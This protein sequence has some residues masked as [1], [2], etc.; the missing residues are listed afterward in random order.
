M[1]MGDRSPRSFEEL[2]TENSDLKER[3]RLLE[4]RY[5]RLFDNIQEA[6]VLRKA[7]FDENGQVADLELIEANPSHL[8]TLKVDSLTEVQGRRYSELYTPGMLAWTIDHVRRAIEIGRPIIEEAH[9]DINN[10]YYLTTTT[11]VDNCLLLSTSVDITERK[12]VEEALRESNEYLER[13]IGYANAPIIVWSPDSVITRF[14]HAFEQ[15]TGIPASEAI[16]SDLSIL[17]PSSSKAS[18]MELIHHAMDGKQWNVVEIP[19][20]HRSGEVRTV[21]WNSANVM[22]SQ[23]RLRATIAQGQDITERVKAETALKKNEKRLSDAQHFAHLGSWEWDLRN[24]D[25]RWSAELYSIFGLSPETFQPTMEK[26]YE[27]IHPDDRETVKSD[28]QQL[29][30]QGTPMNIDF[31][32]IWGDSTVRIINCTGEVSGRDNEGEPQVIV[33][34]N[35]D[36]TERKRVEDEIRRS[37]AELQQFAYVASHDLQEPLRMVVSYLNLLER[38]CEAQ[39]DPKGQ[40]YIHYAVDGGKRMREL[41]DDLLEY[42]RI[43]TRS[44]D[45]SFVDMNQVVDETL[46]VLKVPVEESNAVI[47]VHPLPSLM[48]DGSQMVQLMQNLIGNAI[49]FRGSEPLHVEVNSWH[50]ASEYVISIKDNG[51]GIDEKYRGKLFQMFQRLHT[52]DEY[53]GTGIGLAISKKIVERHGGRIW[54]ES[55]GSHGSTF[56]FTISKDLRGATDE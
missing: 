14:N 1:M 47:V 10:R 8:K 39:L 41:I 32:I 20:Q 43:S 31:R 28:M 3:N 38:R 2:S 46:K 30:S 35:Q 37:N 48:A 12:M 49:K 15:L 27:C 17:F 51:I 33:G 56:F 19:I 26:F 29:V 45:F 22:D 16:G 50:R 13:L 42:S 6:V 44:R 40:E 36:I 9:L 18:S 55:D 25:L 7:I 54:F 23:A 4:E 21:L 11:P 34:T 24:D 52:R 53:A 5:R